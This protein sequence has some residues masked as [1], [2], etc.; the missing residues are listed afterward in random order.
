MDP[1]K[2]DGVTRPQSK[3]AARAARL[4]KELRANLKRR[5]SASG[6]GLAPVVPAEDDAK[7][8]D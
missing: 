8:R 7:P 2:K 6:E 3:K 4:A 5:K 1:P